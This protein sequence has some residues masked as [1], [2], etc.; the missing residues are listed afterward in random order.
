MLRGRIKRIGGV[1]TSELY[2]KSTGFTTSP[3][4]TYWTK[5]IYLTR[6]EALLDPVLTNAEESIRQ[7]KIGGSLGHSDHALVEFMILKNADLAKSKSQDPELQESKILAAQGTA[8]W[9]SLGNCP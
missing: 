5:L 8:E 6:G 4:S 3:Q 7:A 1:F 2:L 9:D